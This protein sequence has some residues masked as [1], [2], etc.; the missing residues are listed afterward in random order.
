MP[1]CN[2]TSCPI[3]PHCGSRETHVT[4]CS[5]FLERGTLYLWD[6]QPYR[7]RCCYKRFYLRPVPREV[8]ARDLT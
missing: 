5:G 8:P 1:N 7:C 2:N 4:R 6:L 3:C